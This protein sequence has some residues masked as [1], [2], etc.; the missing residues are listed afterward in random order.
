MYFTLPILTSPAE[1]YIDAATKR[2]YTWS[3]V[4]NTA[5][6]F[7]RGIRSQWG[8]K[9]GDVLGFF[10]PN[11]VDYA[12]VFFGVHYAGG[13]ASTAN[14]TYTAKELAF[15]MKDSG[16]KGIV[17]QLP[18]LPVVREAARVIGL[19]EDRII[20][21]GDG[22]DPSGKF[23]HFTEIK[24]TGLLG[25]LTSGQTR[26]DP[27]KDLAF[28]VYSSGTTGMPKGVQLTHYNIVSNVAQL[29]RVDRFNGLYHSG[30]LDGQGD[31]QLAIL[32]FFHVY[33]STHRSLDLTWQLLHPCGK[34]N[35][36][37]RALHASHSRAYAWDCRSS[38]YPSSS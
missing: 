9:K 1:I 14:P 29:E 24:P 30:G 16:A 27:Q 21:I 2:S 35:K 32:P 6:E 3:Q 8:F 5:V 19:P 28:L 34:L 33:V 17:T 11:S 26:V 23:K 22:R 12:P 4:K 15:Q 25:A 38:F 36:D 13:A 10:T 7:G 37:I 18:M 31:K 20:L